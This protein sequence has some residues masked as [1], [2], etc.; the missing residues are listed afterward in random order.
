MK[1][2]MKKKTELSLGRAVK[3]MLDRE[4]IGLGSG[5]GSVF[6]YQ[7]KEPKG[8]NKYKNVK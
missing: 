7:P 2:Q 1:K 5:S 3:V 8:M 6:F 4:L